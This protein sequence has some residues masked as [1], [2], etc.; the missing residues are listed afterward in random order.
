MSA[1]ISKSDKADFHASLLNYQFVVAKRQEHLCDLQVGN[2]FQRRDRPLRV[3]IF[4]DDRGADPLD[5][6][7]VRGATMGETIFLRQNQLDFIEGTGAVN[8]LDRCGDRQRTTA[9]HRF[10]SLCTPVILV[11]ST[12]NI[13]GSLATKICI[14]FSLLAGKRARRGSFGHG[15]HLCPVT[16]FHQ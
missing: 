8:Q 12:Q 15:V 13:V 11:H 4:V 3:A 16:G 6:I 9:A 2:F 5:E 10:F 1:H 7:S 14:N